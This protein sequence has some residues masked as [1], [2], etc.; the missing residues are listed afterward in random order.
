[1]IRFTLSPCLYPSSIIFYTDYPAEGKEYKRGQMRKLPWV[2]STKRETWDPD[3]H[4]DIELNSAG[5]YRFQ[6]KRV[7]DGKELEEG[8]GFFLVE[9]DLG[10]SPEGICCQTYITKLMGPFTE[11][12]QRLRVAKEAGYNMAHFTPIQQLGSSRSAYSI[13]DHLRMDSV[14]FP[15]DHTSSDVQKT[16]KDCTGADKTIT[17]DIS[18]VMM[19]E[20]VKRVQK[21]WGLLGMVD[22][23]WNHTAFDT[24]WLKVH[25]EAGYNM[26]N[27]PHL[28]PAYSLDA[29]LRKFSNEIADGQWL[30]RGIRPEIENEGDLNNINACLLDTVLPQAQLWEYFSVDV[31]KIVKEFRSTVYH[32]NGG[33]HPRPHGKRLSIIQDREY[34]RLGST[35]DKDLVLELF[36]VDW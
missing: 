21:E 8:S 32:L 17:V 36:N 4:I 13:S 9:P 1:M 12:E 20:L 26:V 14:Y 11:W 5:P 33:S 34:R 31:E 22:V 24:P 30:H 28:R 29:A 10:Y 18:Y 7:V 35:V 6:Y 2:T 27:S 23:V 19:Q 15:T 3:R 25:P 16:Y